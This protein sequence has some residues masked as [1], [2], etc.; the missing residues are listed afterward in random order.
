MNNQLS[1]F[2]FSFQEV[3][4]PV[5]SSDVGDDTSAVTVEN[6]PHWL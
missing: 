2:D 6:T 1:L 5:Q 3:T 4:V